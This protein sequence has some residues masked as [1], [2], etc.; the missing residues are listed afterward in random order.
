MS[1]IA[2][3]AAGHVLPPPANGAPGTAWPGQCA[4]NEQDGVRRH[5]AACGG[6]N[7]AGER[8]PARPS[9]G[10]GNRAARRLGGCKPARDMITN[11]EAG[12]G[13]RARGSGTEGPV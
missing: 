5:G 11:P 10:R 3:K 13:L 7:P 12:T 4:P 1:I 9:T 8:P 6:T 2:G